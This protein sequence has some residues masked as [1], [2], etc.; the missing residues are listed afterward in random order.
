MSRQPALPKARPASEIL[1]EELADEVLV[2]DQVAHQA[3]CLSPAAAR[4]FRLCDG[5]HTRAEAEAALASEASLDAILAQ[6]TQ[7]GLIVQPRPARSRPDRIDRRRRAMIRKTAFIA[8]AVIA[9]PFIS[10]IVAPPALAASSQCGG[11]LEPCCTSGMACNPP[12]SCKN[13]TCS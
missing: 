12:Y 5:V 7:A 8:G 10:S 2:Y 1:V 9:S 6:L 4:V 3:H 13:G 11:K